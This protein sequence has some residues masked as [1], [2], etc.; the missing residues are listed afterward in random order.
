MSLGRCPL[1]IFCSRGTPPREENDKCHTTEA[2]VHHMR[3][4][5]LNI[6]CISYIEIT[7]IIC[8]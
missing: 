6:I 2:D 5:V 8:Y 7:M 3:L 1:S 4:P